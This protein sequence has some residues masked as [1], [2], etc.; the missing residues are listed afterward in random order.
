M[1]RVQSELAGHNSAALARCRTLEMYRRLSY[2][3]RKHVQA[4]LR[5]NMVGIDGRAHRD[6]RGLA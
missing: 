4:V 2:N 6:L 1:P 5:F 3:C